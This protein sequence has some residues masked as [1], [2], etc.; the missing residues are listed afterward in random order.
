MVERRKHKRHKSETYLKVFDRESE[1]P[2]GELANLS[3][4][5]A[6]LITSERVKES[7]VIKCQVKLTQPIMGHNEIV[8]DAEC[9]WCRKNVKKG[10]WESGYSTNVSGENAELVS[11][12]SLSFELGKWQI[13]G[14]I[15]VKMV[16]LENR[17]KSPRFEV[18]DHFPVYEQHSYRQIGEL[19]D[20]ST[21]G[22]SLIT[23]EAIDK[24]RLL[25]C[26]VKLPKKVF[27]RD[28]LVFDA[29]CMWCRKIKDKDSYESGYQLKNVLEHDAVII[30]HLIIHYLEEQQTKQRVRVVR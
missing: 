15:D 30:L 7:T 20:L 19:A 27:Q 26:R 17:R 21:E 18:K 16:K 25:H 28:Y 8:F 10:W 1:R 23:P 2:I 9:Q 29:E 5:G 22:A 11:Y 12:L 3:P 13:P 4:N 14:P 6:M 24:G